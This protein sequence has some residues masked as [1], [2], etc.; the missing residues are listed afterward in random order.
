MNSSIKFDKF[1]I[2][3]LF[4]TIGNSLLFFSF[5]FV[6][7]FSS[8][9]NQLEPNL[10]LVGKQKNRLDD[11]K[12]LLPHERFYMERWG[13]LTP[14]GLFGDEVELLEE[15]EEGFVRQ[16]RVEEGNED[17]ADEDRLREKLI[18]LYLFIETAEEG[19]E[20]E[21]RDQEC[22]Y[23]LTMSLENDNLVQS[24]NGNDTGYTHG[25][26]TSLIKRCD[27]GRDF[28][29]SLDSQAF[30]DSLYYDAL[31]SEDG[32]WF[33]YV[34]GHKRNSLIVFDEHGERLRLMRDGDY[35]YIDTANLRQ[36]FNQMLEAGSNWYRR[37]I[38]S[39][40]RELSDEEKETLFQRYRSYVEEEN[41]RYQRYEDEALFEKYEALIKKGEEAGSEARV[42][43]FEEK[44]Q[45]SFIFT[46]RRTFEKIY[47][48]LGLV[49]EHISRNQAYLAV[50]EQEIFH[51]ILSNVDK[52][53]KYGYRDGQEN[54][55]SVKA[56]VAAGR[57]LSLNGQRETCDW[58][59]RDS[60]RL[61]VGTELSTL[62]HNSSVYIS[63]ELDKSLPFFF[64]GL[65]LFGAAKLSYNGSEERLVSTGL[66]LSVSPNVRFHFSVKRRKRV[67]KS[68]SSL[69]YDTDDDKLAFFGVTVY[70]GKV[71][72]ENL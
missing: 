40:E 61:E 9:S 56:I 49:L 11:Y 15:G 62:S 14:P 6:F 29:V 70:L 24:S 69:K 23:F 32:G 45:L 72:R 30:T 27:S 37:S 48:T 34:W 71:V 16:A 42:H 44:N 17:F 46:N 28:I 12:K 43:E 63:S 22:R 31:P 51:D 5:G 60:L 41:A 2:K 39:G 35:N 55:Y 13:S 1:K 54:D 7:C 25:H 58:W 18:P 47:Y 4:K 8:Y 38:R 53:K 68:D 52:A 50:R 10:S 36:D 67:D 59:C 3:G 21:S 65:S 57:N 20:I 19:D 26:F 33:A 64:K 66:R